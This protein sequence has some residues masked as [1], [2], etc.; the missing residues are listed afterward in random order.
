MIPVS[1][2]TYKGKTRQG[3][4]DR[5]PPRSFQTLSGVSIAQFIAAY[6]TLM[7]VTANLSKFEFFMVPVENTPPKNQVDY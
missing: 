3:A 2:P 6:N 4:K 1:L 5:Y 7:N